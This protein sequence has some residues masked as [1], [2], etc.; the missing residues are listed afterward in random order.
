MTDDNKRIPAWG[1]INNKTVKG[2]VEIQKNGLLFFDQSNRAFSF[3][4]LWAEI[5]YK[6]EIERTS[7]FLFLKQERR[8]IKP[9]GGKKRR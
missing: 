7:R 6:K 3:P 8:S 2:T 5:N 1:S 9:S 4:I